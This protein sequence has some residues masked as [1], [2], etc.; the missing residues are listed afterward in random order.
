MEG[1]GFSELPEGESTWVFPVV[2]IRFICLHHMRPL[3]CVNVR[4]ASRMIFPLQPCE[5]TENGKKGNKPEMS[6]KVH[7]KV[8]SGRAEM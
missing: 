2:S 1:C 7:R 6:S 5:G 8:R 3:P 4:A